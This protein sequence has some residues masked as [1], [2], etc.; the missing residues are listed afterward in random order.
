MKFIKLTQLN[1][2]ETFEPTRRW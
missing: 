2:V 1:F